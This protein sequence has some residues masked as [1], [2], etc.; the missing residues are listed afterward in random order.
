M[1]PH[2]IRNRLGRA[3]AVSA[4]GKHQRVRAQQ[5]KR[6]GT[7]QR[8][9]VV[10][11]EHVHFRTTAEQFE[12]LERVCLALKTERAIIIRDALDIY[13][14]IAEAEFSENNELPDLAP[15][16]RKPRRKRKPVTKPPD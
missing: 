5:S 6:R 8:G 11:P 1:P 12:R 7:Y 13:L 2:I 4:A 10:Y 16:V 9:V 14:S 3:L 15:V